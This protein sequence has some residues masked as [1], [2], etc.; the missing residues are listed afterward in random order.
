MRASERSHCYRRP[1]GLKRPLQ[2]A[3]DGAAI[4]SCVSVN[5]M[6]RVPREPMRVVAVA[7]ACCLFWVWASPAVSEELEVGEPAPSFSLAGSDATAYTLESI[8]ASGKQGVVLAWFPK[9]FTPG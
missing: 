2:R 7:L 4:V 5:S 8:L 9:A 1:R 3:W 6:S